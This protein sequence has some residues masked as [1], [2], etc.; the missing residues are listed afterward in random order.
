LRQ[1]LDLACAWFKRFR[2]AARF[3]EAAFSLK[4]RHL[5]ERI[6]FF[7]T[8]D[9]IRAA[10]EAERE[11]DRRRDAES[12]T[13]RLYRTARWRARRD[14]Q[15]RREP[16]CCRCIAEGFITPATI[17]NHKWRHNGDPVLFWTIP[18][19]STCKTCHDGVIQ[20]EENLA[21][22]AGGRGKSPGP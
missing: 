15:L 5:P 12:E 7:R 8:P 22:R 18:L 17:A 19:E 2:D 14:D 10:K 11:Y 9:Q 6:G 16:L 21:A 3:A 13:R 4:G 20:A 1:S